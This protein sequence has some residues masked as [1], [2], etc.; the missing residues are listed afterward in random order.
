MTPADPPPPQEGTGSEASPPEASAT[1]CG[2][3]AIIG[4]PNAGKS[5]LVNRLVGTK[6]TIVSRKVQT[7]RMP[8]RG[9]F[10]VGDTQLVLI[11]TPGIFAPR[12]RLD[13]AMVG[14]AWSGANDAD[15]IVFMID[16]ARG[17]DDEA[18]AILE[19]L[20]D[21][22]SPVYV[23]LNKV[24]R[25][26]DKTALLALADRVRGEI[27]PKEIFFISAL[28]GDGVEALKEMLAG[29]MP[30]GPWHYPADDVSDLPMRLLAAE[31]T[32]EKIYDRLHQELPYAIN[33][34]TTD[35]KNL[36][37]GSVRIEQTVFVERDSQKRIVL[38]KGG[39]L[40]KQVSQETRLELADILGHP[41]HLFLFVK[42]RENWADDPRRYR[43]MG[44]E[45][46][47][48]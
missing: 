14:A 5:T 9:I 29:D 22:K 24:D 1:R 6:V 33:V 21:V 28:D 45:F 8:V 35:W 41:V 17:L 39:R 23:A 47:K 44:L 38:G 2:F 4:A 25:L 3:V 46:P 20:K 19:Q 11:D 13:R 30:E 26:A 15:A 48:D 7:T 16:A 31:L 12:R 43:E 27:A 18:R 34:E 40:I 36:R 10:I 32:R 42:V 37:N